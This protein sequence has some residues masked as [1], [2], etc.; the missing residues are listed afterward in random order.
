VESTTKYNLI[1]IL[2]P[3][4]SGK[5]RL[6]VTVARHLNTEIISADSRQVYKGMDLGTGKDLQIYDSLGRCV[7]Y[8]LINIV[9]PMKDFSVYDFQKRFYEAHAKI[10]T[11][12]RIPIL[13]G[14]TGMYLDCVLR[15][16]R[17][18]EVPENPELRLKISRMSEGEILDLLRSV[19]PELHNVTDTRD[20]WRMTRALEIHTFEKEHKDLL[21]NPPLTINSLNFG[22][23]IERTALRQG[24]RKRLHERIEAGMLREAEQLHEMGVPW[25]RFNYFGLEYRYMAMYLQ[26]QISLSLMKEEL[27]IRIG[28]F[29]KRQETWFRKMEREGIEIIWVGE[30]DEAFVMKVLR[31]KGLLDASN[32]AG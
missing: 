9:D 20:R 32:A 27:A 10:T 3:T 31:D 16:Y 21:G 18:V 7:S 28:Q 12:S 11:K 19:G 30:N 23:A 2:G 22:M 29:A 25:E 4:A 6:G 17:M 13:V 26:R 14:G 5:T 1:T 8:H 24:I 15:G